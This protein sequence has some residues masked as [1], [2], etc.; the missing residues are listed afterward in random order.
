VGEDGGQFK[1][2]DIVYYDPSVTYAL[3]VVTRPEM[4]RIRHNVHQREG[5]RLL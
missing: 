4:P 2:V 3:P 5:R 1:I